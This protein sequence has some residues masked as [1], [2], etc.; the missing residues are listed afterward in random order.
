MIGLN[1]EMIVLAHFLEPFLKAMFNKPDSC[2]V[3]IRHNR[4][5]SD[6][7]EL[8]CVVEVYSDNARDTFE[9]K[10]EFEENSLH[11][12]GLVCAGSFNGA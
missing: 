6:L 12:S 10:I 9:E 7:N 2:S 1:G 11:N 5:S 3:H 4:G 8:G